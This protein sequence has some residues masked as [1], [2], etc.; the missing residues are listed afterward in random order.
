[1]LRKVNGAMSEDTFVKIM[2]VPGYSEADQ[3]VQ[4][5]QSHGIPAF[6]QGGLQ[7]VYMGSSMMGQDILVREKDAA[8]ARELLVEFQPVSFQTAYSRKG[9]TGRQKLLFGIILIL[10]IAAVG[11][12]VLLFL[13]H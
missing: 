7:D 9:R 10:L 11:F 1:M 6:Y 13:M 4:I 8:R 2:D 12:S 5:L 3:I